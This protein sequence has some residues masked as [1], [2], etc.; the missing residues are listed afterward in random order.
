MHVVADAEQELARAA[1]RPLVVLQDFAHHPQ[2]RGIGLAIAGEAEPA[3]EL[4]VAQ[5]AGGTLEIGLEQIHRLAE[6]RAFVGPRPLDRFHKSPPMS[7][8]IANQAALEFLE[9][10][11][12]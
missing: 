1:E 11:L 5:P 8:G 10:R 4:N 3:D 2:A 9:K 7:A 12:A 6:L